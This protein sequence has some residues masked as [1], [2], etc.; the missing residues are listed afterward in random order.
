MDSGIGIPPADISHLFE[1][2]FRASNVETRGTG[3]GLSISRRIVEA[4]GGRIWAESPYPEAK[5]GSKFSFILP[6]LT[7]TKRR[8]RR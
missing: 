5:R 2:F 3:L 4:H 7:E 8:Q 6:K 1:D